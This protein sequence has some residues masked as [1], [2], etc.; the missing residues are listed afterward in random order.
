MK[1]QAVKITLFHCLNS[2]SAEDIA[3]CN[4]HLE[5]AKLSTISLPCSGKVNL[6]YILKAIETGADAAIL[7]GCP[8]G[9]CKFLQGNL[10]AQ[11][12]IE[13]INDLLD[14]TGIGREHV[15]FIQLNGGDRSEVILEEI[16]NYCER[17]NKEQKS[18]QEID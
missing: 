9:E 11:K 10:R 8:K 7:T 15:R 18:I 5:N 13:A 6:Q 3:K 16:K 14:E 2:L 1:N 12:R 4:L 17:F